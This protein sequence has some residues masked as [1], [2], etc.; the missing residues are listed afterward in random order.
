M[1]KRYSADY[2]VITTGSVQEALGVLSQLHDDQ[3]QVSL[4]LADQWLPE[5]TGTELL[6]Q[7]RQ[8]HPAARR[9]LL[10]TW[11]DQAMAEPI[12]RATVLAAPAHDRCT[13]PKLTMSRSPTL[14]IAASFMYS[15]TSTAWRRPEPIPCFAGD[16]RPH[17]D[18]PNARH[19]T[20]RRGIP[21]QRGIGDRLACE[22]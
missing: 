5:A 22:R 12:L 14:A 19:H 9:V 6:A 2:Q 18:G 7:V 21:Q 4:V 3:R 1:R 11:V 20:C 8:F 15:P 17:R 13:I 10:A 16:G